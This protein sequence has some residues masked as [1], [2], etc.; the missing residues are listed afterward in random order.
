MLFYKVISWDTIMHGSLLF[1]CTYLLTST[2]ILLLLFSWFV[3]VCSI[4]MIIIL[5]E[6]ATHIVLA[7][8]YS[9]K[10]RYVYICWYLYVDKYIALSFALCYNISHMHAT[11]ISSCICDRA[12]Q[13]RSYRLILYF[14]KYEFQ[15]WMH[16]ASLHGGLIQ[17]RQIS[18]IISVV[19]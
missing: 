2:I 8:I 18:C 1:S 6:L 4:K 10:M 7:Q 12:W 5:A 9:I 13:N 15:Y 14:E 17:S 16:C 19:I 3:T 11:L